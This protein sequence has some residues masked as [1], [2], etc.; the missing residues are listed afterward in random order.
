[1]IATVVMTC[2]ASVDPVRG[3][4]VFAHAAGAWLHVDAAYA[5]SCWICDEERWSQDGVELADSLVINPHKW[6]MTPM[7]CSLLWTSRPDELRTAFSFTPEYLRTDDDVYA[8]SD[9]GPAL[10]RRSGPQVGGAA[11]AARAAATTRKHVRRVNLLAARRRPT[12]PGS[13]CAPQRF[14]VV[15]PP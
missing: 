12:R 15:F 2:L 8:L 9:Y 10:G 4:A 3:L 14:L 11:T 6:L 5:G 1:V 7:D 13:S